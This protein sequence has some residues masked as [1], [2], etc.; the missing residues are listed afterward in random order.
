MTIHI[1]YSF[2]RHFLPIFAVLILC[3]KIVQLSK[4][5]ET[6][7]KQKSESNGTD[8]DIH[9]LDIKTTEI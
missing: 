5:Q 1:L 4:N 2:N 7:L 9:G 8:L 3:E 6:I